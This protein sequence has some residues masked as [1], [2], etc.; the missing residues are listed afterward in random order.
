ML[1]E[2]SIY[3]QGPQIYC[4]TFETYQTKTLELF[5]SMISLLT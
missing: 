1:K 2:Y 4:A 3:E 5:A